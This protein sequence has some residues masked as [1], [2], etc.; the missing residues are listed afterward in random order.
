MVLVPPHSTGIDGAASFANR[1]SPLG[2]L[3]RAQIWTV[4]MDGIASMRPIS[5]AEELQAADDSS[6]RG[7]DDVIAVCEAGTALCPCAPHDVCQHGTVCNGRMCALP[8]DDDKSETASVAEDAN[9]ARI[10]FSTSTSTL[11][12]MLLV[13]VVC[14]VL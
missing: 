6:L 2:E 5:N 7:L 10:C 12:F 1:S 13:L 9:T 8:I 4:D 11:C 3:G 14:L